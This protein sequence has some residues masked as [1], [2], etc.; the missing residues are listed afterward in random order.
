M[1][2]SSSSQQP[3]KRSRLTRSDCTILIGGELHS[4]RN[5][6]KYAFRYKYPIQRV[7]KH[8]GNPSNTITLTD[9]Q[10]SRG[11]KP[12]FFAVF[13][14]RKDPPPPDEYILA[15]R[16]WWIASQV[17]AM[18]LCGFRNTQA[19]GG[20]CLGLRGDI[21]LIAQLYVDHHIAVCEKPIRLFL[22]DIDTNE[23]LRYTVA[24]KSWDKIE[25]AITIHSLIE[26][27][28]R[29]IAVRSN[30]VINEETNSVIKLMFKCED[31]A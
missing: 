12:V 14:L 10:L 24:T 15:Q 16:D 5:W 22:Y 29:K 1:S 25:K 11:R 2:S 4:D 9:H 6:A 28:C 8:S 31:T 26:L 27:G 18:V 3:P 19:S 23:W 7:G 20:M 17:D 30:H 21:R 13:K